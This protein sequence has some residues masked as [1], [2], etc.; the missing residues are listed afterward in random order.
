MKVFIHI[1]GAKT[2]STAIQ[3]MLFRN[4]NLLLKHDYVYHHFNRKDSH[5]LALATG[6][7][8]TKSKR[9]FS[10]LK[11]NQTQIF[12]HLKTRL[13]PTKNHIIS[14][15]VFSIATTK[16]AV[17]TLL[18]LFTEF[19]VQI[20]FYLR[21]QADQTA[22]A[23][24][25]LVKEGYAKP[26][27]IFST[28][29]KVDLS[30]SLGSFLELLSPQNFTLRPYESQYFENQN[31]FD[32][33]LKCIEL[34]GSKKISKPSKSESNQSL[35]KDCIEVLRYCNVKFPNQT[36]KFLKE[37]ESLKIS[38]DDDLQYLP[39]SKKEEINKE[40]SH[41]IEWLKQKL[42]GKINHDFITTEKEN[43]PLYQ[44]LEISGFSKVFIAS[45]NSNMG[46][47]KKVEQDLDNYLNFFNLDEQEEN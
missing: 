45:L 46:K 38:D 30:N 27:E 3:K 36:K 44:G 6:F 29:H 16:N 4:T 32:D 43:K 7:G 31:L 1:G 5:E 24:Q 25:Q 23:F 26:V 41:Q 42:P 14:S 10:I 37:L 15:E 22:S 13:D 21:N 11:I 8:I 12:N 47:L 39:N 9:L 28:N 20:I 17:E 18:G 2:G 40:F 34:D 19:E 35:S 33:F